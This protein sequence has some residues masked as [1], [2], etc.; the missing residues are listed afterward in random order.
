VHAVV[1][2]GVTPPDLEAADAVTVTQLSPGDPPGAFAAAIHRSLTATRRASRYS[3]LHTPT[4]TQVL[5]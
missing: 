3:V 4:G 1:L 5:S 2:G